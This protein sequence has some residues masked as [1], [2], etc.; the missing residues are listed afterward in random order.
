MSIEISEN[1]DCTALKW[2]TN[3][4][5]GTENHEATLVQNTIE[6]THIDES[7]FGYFIQFN[8]DGTFVSYNPRFLRK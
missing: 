5:L 4:V 7:P 1:H 2:R 3:F 6:L 8:E